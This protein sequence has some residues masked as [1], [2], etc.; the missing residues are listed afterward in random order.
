MIL[1]FLK[2]GLSDMLFSTAKH[3]RDLSNLGYWSG[4][5]WQLCRDEPAPCANIR[6]DSMLTKSQWFIFKCNYTLTKTYFF[7]HTDWISFLTLW[8]F[9]LSMNSSIIFWNTSGD[10][11]HGWISCSVRWSLLSYESHE[12]SRDFMGQKTAKKEKT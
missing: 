8:I 12:T 4:S 11:A 10:Q 6:A 2:L 7:L 1:H 9:K 5:T 3:E